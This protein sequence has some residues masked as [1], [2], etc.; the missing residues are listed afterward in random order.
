MRSARWRYLR[1]QLTIQV[2]VR[3]DGGWQRLPAERLV[4]GDLIYLRVGDMVP[5]DVRLSGGN[6]LVDHS[7]VTGEST[8]IDAGAGDTAYTGGLIKRGEA[9]ALVTATGSRTYFGKTAELVRQ[10]KAA[11]HLQQMIF[12]VVKYLVAFDVVL[13]GFVLIYALSVG[14][15]AGDILPFCLMLLVASIPVALPATFTLASALGTQ[16][17][18]HGEYWS[19]VCRPSRKRRRWM[20]SQP[21]RPVRSQKMSCLWRWWRRCRPIPRRTSSGLPRSPPTRRRRTRLT[22]RFSRQPVAAAW[23]RMVSTFTSSFP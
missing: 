6:V 11:G 3:R 4:Q 22:S 17:L 21:T 12:T 10:A 23:Q 15:G 5:A 8:P 14:M 16:E 18:A 2:R 20:C 9:T 13:A 1:R 19:A 7:A